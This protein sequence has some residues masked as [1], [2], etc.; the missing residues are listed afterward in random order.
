MKPLLI[1]LFAILSLFSLIKTQYTFNYAVQGADWSGTCSTGREQS[2]ININSNQITF[3][4][5]AN[6]NLWFSKVNT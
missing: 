3:R 4:N 6:L 5:N 1:L 2:P